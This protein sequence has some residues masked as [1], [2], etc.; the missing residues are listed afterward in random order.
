MT[1][2]HPTL[3]LWGPEGTFRR[4]LL[5]YEPRPN[6]EAMYN[7]VLQAIELRQHLIVEAGTGIGKSMAYLTPAIL[8]AVRDPD[9]RVAISTAT[10]NLQ[11]QLVNKDLPQTEAALVADQLIKPGELRWTALKGKAN[12][13][14]LHQ[15]EAAAERQMDQDGLLDRISRWNT[16]T[17]DVAELPLTTE[18]RWHWG[19]VSAQ[20]SNNCP[21][22]KS[23]HPSCHLLRARNRARDA[24][25]VVVNHALLLSDIAAMDPYLG[26]VKQVVI[27]EAHHLEE[28]ASSQFG[29]EINPDDL[30]RQI[31]QLAGDPVLADAANRFQ[32]PWDEYW[33]AMANCLDPRRPEESLAV[34]PRLRQTDSWQRAQEAA[35]RMDQYLEAFAEQIAAQIAHASRS[36]DA[37]RET[38]L[39]PIAQDIAEH[40]ERI[41]T[42]MEEHDPETVQW[43]R[44]RPERQPT[45]HAVPLRVG[46]TLTE[47]LF[48]RRDTVILTSATLASGKRGFDLL[49]QQVGFTRGD[50]LAL[51]SP[52]DYPRQARLMSPADLPNP[53]DFQEHSQASAHAMAGVCRELDGHTLA[54]FTSNAAI[55]DAARRLRPEMESLGITVLAQNVDGSAPEILQRF[56]HNSRA[57]I[58]GT[59]SFWEGIDLAPEHLHAVLICRLPFP[60][61]TDPVLSARSGLYADPFR[62]YHVPTAVLRFRQGFGRL[63]RNHR[64]RGVVVIL[65][66]RIRNRGYGREFVAA[67]PECNYAKSDLENVGALAKQWMQAAPARPQGADR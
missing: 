57:I 50:K 61:P 38:V 16:H 26:H 66:P 65:D 21:L 56:R 55:R 54:L 34:S 28:E 49:V 12:Y 17:G 2:A 8:A 48:N 31:S 44:P 45:V 41:E 9:V 6:Q 5:G 25:I 58:L 4:H 33:Q 53:K 46:P 20:Y 47:R 13:L 7:A 24:H 22:Y 43:I 35:Q 63:V 27:D 19:A 10:I 29:W 60:V 18:Q 39:R 30:S 40:R 52:F 51:P 36:G 1:D 62:D 67:L 14:C 11:E 23:G 3:D 32:H 59:N 15:Y 64:S 37:P 42:L